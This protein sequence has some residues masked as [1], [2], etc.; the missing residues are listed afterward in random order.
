MYGKDSWLC[1]CNIRSI[2]WE[3]DFQEIKLSQEM[4]C[5][6]RGMLMWWR[7]LLQAW[8]QG[9]AL[10]ET[11]VITSLG[12]LK[13]LRVPSGSFVSWR[14]MWIKNSKIATAYS[15]GAASANVFNYHTA[16]KAST[17]CFSRR[18]MRNHNV[19][20]VQ[21]AHQ[22]LVVNEYQKVVNF[23]MVFRSSVYSNH[24]NVWKFESN[25]H[26]YVKLF[27]ALKRWDWQLCCRLSAS[28]C[29]VGFLLAQ[30]GMSQMFVPAGIAVG[31]CCSSSGFF[32]QVSS[33]LQDSCSCHT[34]KISLAF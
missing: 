20:F 32:C 3:L 34:S 5:V 1:M 8:R 23:K 18:I 17:S 13:C 30:N 19:A 26:N 22:L 10:G 28:V 9:L 21:W 2:C 29:K 16:V 24:N 27:Q 25:F 7:K 31:I 12:T 6:C 33:C 14:K 11:S 4:V 15:V